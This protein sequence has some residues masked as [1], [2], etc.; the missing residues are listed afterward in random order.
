MLLTGD[1]MHT[2]MYW[3]LGQHEEQFSLYFCAAEMQTRVGACGK[4][5]VIYNLHSI[6]FSGPNMVQ[7]GVIMLRQTL[8]VLF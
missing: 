3:E 5:T 2:Q 4:N 7:P 1:K 6:Y 8:P